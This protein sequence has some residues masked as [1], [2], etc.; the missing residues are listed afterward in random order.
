MDPH[1]RV[2]FSRHSPERLLGK[3]GFRPL[4]WNTRSPRLNRSLLVSSVFPAL[5]R[6]AFDEFERRTGRNPLG[7]K[8][9]LFGLFQ[10][11]LPIDWA[12]SEAG[13]GE[14]MNCIAVAEG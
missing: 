14:L 6:H 12:A 1:G 3:A 7:R 10:L 11:G 13:L 9:I 4:T 5:H 8:V 2:Q